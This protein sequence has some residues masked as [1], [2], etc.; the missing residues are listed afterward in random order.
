M[1]PKARKLRVVV[2]KIDEELLERLDDMARAW[3]VSRSEI[4]REAI[5]QYLLRARSPRRVKLES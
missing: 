2:F 5:R 4:I 3:G 1:R